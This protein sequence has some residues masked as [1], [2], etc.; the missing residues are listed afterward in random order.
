MR[1]PA[2]ILLVALVVPVFADESE[3]WRKQF[4]ET[5]KLEE[6]QCLKRIPPPF[7]PEREIYY[8]VVDSGQAQ[9]IPKP[10]DYFTFH[11]DGG[12]K[13]WG[14][15][16]T[17]GAKQSTG[18][19]LDSIL[20]MKNYEYQL[21][22]ELAKFKMNGDWIIDTKAESSVKLAALCN[23]IKQAGGPGAKFTQKDLPRK[24]V[25]ATGEYVP[26]PLT[27][28]HHPT[29]IHLYVDKPDPTEGSGGGSGDFKE[30]LEMLGSR[31]GMQVIDEV[32]GDKPARLTWGHHSSTNLAQLAGLPDGPQRDERIAKLLE[33]VSQQT[34]IHFKQ[35]LRMLPTWVAEPVEAR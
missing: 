16:F 33:I 29:W 26:H 5:Y 6:G 30:L 24:V 19:V 22:P 3:P 2:M 32:I 1:F 15:G 17:S 28:I 18:S 31:V 20:M 8:K 11:W 21:F 7:I 14:C 23:I 35:E 27:D 9:H 34:E 13:Q 12:L 4:N 25:V 10:P